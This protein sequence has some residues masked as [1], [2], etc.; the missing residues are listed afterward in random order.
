MSQNRY[1]AVSVDGV[2]S[3]MSEECGGVFSKTR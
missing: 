2:V 1:L 3:E